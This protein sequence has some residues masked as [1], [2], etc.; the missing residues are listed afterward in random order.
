MN[1]NRPNPFGTRNSRNFFPVGND[2][3]SGNKFTGRVYV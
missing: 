3:Q 1:V 2:F